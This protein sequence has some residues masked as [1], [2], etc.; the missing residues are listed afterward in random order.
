[1]S[2][3]ANLDEESFRRELLK[4]FRQSNSLLVRIAEDVRKIKI[5]TS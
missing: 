4:L 1:M 2:S 3:S 5:N